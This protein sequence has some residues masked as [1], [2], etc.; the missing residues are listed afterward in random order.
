M[1]T[2]ISIFAQPMGIVLFWLYGFIGDYGLSIIIFTI[3]IRTIIFPLTASQLKQTARTSELQPKMQKLQKQY[4]HDREL[5]NQKIMELYQEE[6][7]NP[8]KGCLPLLIQLP[9]ILGLFSLLR[10]PMAYVSNQDMLLVIHESFLWIPDLSQPDN[11]ILPILAAITTFFS[12]KLT[13]MSNPMAGGQM[14]SAMKVMQYIFPLMI[15]WWGRTFPAGLTI[16]WFISTLYQCLQQQLIYY[17]MR[18]EKKKKEE[19]QQY[20]KEHPELFADEPE[21]EEKEDEKVIQKKK[22]KGLLVEMKEEEEEDF[23]N[24]GEI[25]TEDLDDYSDFYTEEELAQR[26]KELAH[27]KA[28]AKYKKKRT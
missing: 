18:K 8:M 6:G 4:G 26:E 15:L 13:S 23:W 12:Y 21:E 9:I 7:V 17:L 14:N 5:Y 22:K 2:F 28:K 11:W 19:E 10:N 25:S 16:Y 20:R 24:D 27:E 1:E 3:L